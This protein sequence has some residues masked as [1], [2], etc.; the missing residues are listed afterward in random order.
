MNAVNAFVFVLTKKKLVNTV[1]KKRSPCP[2]YSLGSKESAKS[3]NMW[4]WLSFSL[5]RCG[6]TLEGNKLS[7]R[8]NKLLQR[9]SVVVFLR[10]L[11]VHF[12]PAPVPSTLPALVLL[13][14]IQSVCY[15][16]DLP[17]RESHSTTHFSASHSTLAGR[18]DS[19][20]PDSLRSGRCAALWCVY[21]CWW[22]QTLRKRH[23][24]IS[25][26][27]F[28]RVAWLQRNSSPL[29]GGVSKPLD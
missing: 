9:L 24:E 5:E 20:S 19:S 2:C 25:H 27:L 13:F 14:H 28:W 3:D 7:R 8:T 4:T 11:A 15:G 6:R 12:T 29:Y 10:R 22:L 21:C 17:G 18:G 23:G 26:K 16:N 1:N